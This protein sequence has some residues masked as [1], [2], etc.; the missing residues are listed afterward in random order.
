MRKERYL[1]ASN[2]DESDGNYN[3]SYSTIDAL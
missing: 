1:T 2:P 3:L